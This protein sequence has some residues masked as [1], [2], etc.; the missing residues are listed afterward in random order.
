MNTHMK[1]VEPVYY[2]YLETNK[3]CPDNQSFLIFQVVLYEKVQFRT[4]TK[5]P[6]H[7][8][9]QIFKCPH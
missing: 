7:T 1:T 6:D 4:S 2:G 8:G 9:V 3:M 5:C